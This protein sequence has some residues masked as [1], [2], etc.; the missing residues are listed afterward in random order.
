MICNERFIHWALSKN[1]IDRQ[2][3]ILSFY[4]DGMRIIEWE[5]VIEEKKDDKEYHNYFYIVSMKW[6]LVQP[7]WVFF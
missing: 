1:A 6:S 5:W 4:R 3:V 2:Y 7:Q